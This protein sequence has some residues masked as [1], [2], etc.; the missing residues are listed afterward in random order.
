MVRTE[1]GVGW[2]VMGL[3]E[4]VWLCH[5]G[6]VSGQFKFRVENTVPFVPRSSG[7]QKLRNS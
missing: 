6:W 2:V 1:S 4:L 7:L 3:P 5:R